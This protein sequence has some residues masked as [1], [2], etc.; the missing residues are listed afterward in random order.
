MAILGSLLVSA[1]SNADGYPR[2][3]IDDYHYIFSADCKPYMDWQSA[4]LFQSWRAV[5]SPGRITRLLSCDE[6]TLSTYAY[7]D[8]MPTHVTP[9]FDHIDPNDGYAAYNLPGSMLYV[10]GLSQIQDTLFQL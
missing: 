3:E 9:R 1:S 10:P 6:Q 2:R 8:I 5:G 4:A 7:L